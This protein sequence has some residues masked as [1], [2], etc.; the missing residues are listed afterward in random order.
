MDISVLRTAFG[1]TYT[2]G[3][4]SCRDLSLWTLE[5][6]MREVSGVPVCDWK[7]HG[8]SAIPVGSY[9]VIV[10]YSNRFKKELPLLIGVE[11]FVGVRIHSGN[12]SEDTEGCILV[13]KGL[14]QAGDRITD[15]RSAM[16]ELMQLL[17]GAY[18]KG[19][20]VWL[21]IQ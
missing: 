6:T 19:E 18:D 5:D 1:K 15:S 2:I 20:E 12:S 3:H 21:H 10:N 17:D 8:C 4:M 9:Q 11:G 13:G 16:N 7:Q 14:N